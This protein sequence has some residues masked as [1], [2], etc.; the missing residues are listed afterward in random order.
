MVTIIIIIT[1]M[2]ENI[3]QLTPQAKASIFTKYTYLMVMVTT[4]TTKVRC[5]YPTSWGNERCA[6]TSLLMTDLQK[7]KK[8][9]LVFVNDIK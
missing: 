3:Q 4:I 2:T 6:T 1:Y 8:N 5:D 9:T 7:K